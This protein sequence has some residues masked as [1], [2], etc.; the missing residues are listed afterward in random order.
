[1]DINPNTFCIQSNNCIIKERRPKNYY[2]LI[3]IFTFQDTKMLVNLLYRTF[4]I[5]TSE[6]GR[7]LHFC[8]YSYHT[9]KHNLTEPKA[10][11]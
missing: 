3:F 8:V 5:K 4:N 11:W 10:I 9:Y 6:S 7:S 2:L 1:M